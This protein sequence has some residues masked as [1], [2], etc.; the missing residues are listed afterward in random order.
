M[1]IKPFSRQES[2]LKQFCYGGDAY[3]LCEGL[4]QD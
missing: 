3:G 4:I 1:C 2:A